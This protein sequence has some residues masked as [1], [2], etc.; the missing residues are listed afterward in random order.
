MPN[1]KKS[2][3]HA[4]KFEPLIVPLDHLLSNAV[5]PPWRAQDGAALAR[6]T[7]DLGLGVWQP[8]AV[9]PHPTRRGYYEIG[10]GHR[11]LAA[12]RAL[13][14]SEVEVRVYHGVSAETLFALLNRDSQT[15]DGRSWFAAWA[16]LPAADRE[17]FRAGQIP[18]T[19]AANIATLVELVGQARAVALGQS[20]AG[21]SPAVAK[22][23]RQA[24]AWL[25]AYKLPSYP[26][27]AALV[28][29]AIAHHAS[30]ALLHL[31]GH[32]PIEFARKLINRVQRDRPF[33]EREWHPIPRVIKPSESGEIA[34]VRVPKST[35]LPPAPATRIRPLAKA[36]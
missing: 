19:Q 16:R 10:D 34:A 3:I 6:L 7:A 21:V 32:P 33:P 22:R 8:P 18:T 24:E 14:W 1:T 4:L 13:G 28:E 23:A 27:A 35:E 36:G 15:I 20:E 31:A 30:T 29:W 9:V 5:Q 2:S 12:A 26:T 17:P 11:R 25:R